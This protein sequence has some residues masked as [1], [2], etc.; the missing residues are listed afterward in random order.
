MAAKCKPV[1]PKPSKPKTVEVAPYKRAA[2]RKPSRK[3]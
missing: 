1:Y 3:C 2:P